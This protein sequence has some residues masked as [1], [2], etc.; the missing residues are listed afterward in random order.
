MWRILKLVI[1]FLNFNIPSILFL[2]FNIPSD[3][4]GH[5]RMKDLEVC[6]VNI[7]CTILT[8]LW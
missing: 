3:V 4:Q 6:D 7:V 5:V 1:L 2:N 8:L